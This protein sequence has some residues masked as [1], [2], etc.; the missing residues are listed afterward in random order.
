MFAT[1]AGML[2][3][4]ASLISVMAGI[5][6]KLVVTRLV[7]NKA[8][9]DVKKQI[10]SIVKTEAVV[11]IGETYAEL[12]EP[13]WRLYETD[14]QKFLRGELSS[15]ASF[16]H[17]LSVA[18][19]LSKKGLTFIDKEFIEQ[20]DMKNNRRVM[21]AYSI[22]LNNLVCCAVPQAQQQRIV[23]MILLQRQKNALS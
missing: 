22:I 6:V 9:A 21:R 17:D 16:W 10:Q 20:N 12:I 13:W 15:R 8:H 3:A 18:N 19:L 4:V 23:K 14:Y 1:F 5:I 11:T 7:L 2:L